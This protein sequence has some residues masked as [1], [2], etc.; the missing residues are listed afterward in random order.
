M[1]ITIRNKRYKLS[2]GLTEFV[3][4][5]QYGLGLTICLGVGVLLVMA[6]MLAALRYGV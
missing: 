4:G 1:I 3:R 5:F 6:F 2:P